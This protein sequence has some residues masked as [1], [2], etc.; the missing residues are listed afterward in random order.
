[1][2][3]HRQKTPNNTTNSNVTPVKSLRQHTLMTQ[4]G[5]TESERDMVLIQN[6]FQHNLKFEHEGS[7]YYLQ[8]KD[9]L[10]NSPKI[11]CVENIK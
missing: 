11:L 4:F 7:T 1:M 8:D 9:F 10:K 6:Y 2:N 3:I 5:A